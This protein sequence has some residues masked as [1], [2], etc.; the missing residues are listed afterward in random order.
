MPIKQAERRVSL[1]TGGSSGFG[2]ALALELARNNLVVNI[3][4][5]DGRRGRR[6]V[7]EIRQASGNPSVSLW[8]GDLSSRQSMN[9]NADRFIKNHQ[10]L[11]VLINNAA[12]ILPRRQLNADGVELSFA[13]GHLG[14]FILTN[15]LLELMRKTECSQILNVTSGVHR[16]QSL[17]FDDLD[18]RSNYHWMAAYSRVK[19][20]N[21][22]FTYDL[23]RRECESGIAV[24]CMHP[25]GLRTNIF[26]QHSKSRRWLM[27]IFSRKPDKLAKKVVDYILSGDMARLSGYYLKGTRVARSAAQTYDQK[28]AVDLWDKSMRLASVGQ[29]HSCHG[30][31]LAD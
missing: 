6:A 2:K 3:L 7:E 8:V 9:E 23:A 1:V 29:R 31:T 21:I 14:H 30:P 26:H 4:C 18:N 24:N 20:A 27:G 10:R 12:V 22:L 25:G 16:R 5:R 19:L 15:R 17:G 28:M 13:I 11:D